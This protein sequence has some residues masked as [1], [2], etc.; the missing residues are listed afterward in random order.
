MAEIE[1]RVEIKAPREVVF[2][3]LVDLCSELRW[4]PGVE[5]MEKLTEGPVRLGTRYRAKWTQSG[6]IICECTRFDR[7][8]GWSYHNGGPIEV[9]LNIALTSTPIG[10]ILTSRFDARP[11]GLFKLIFPIFLLM[12]RKQERE[13]MV[14][15]KRYVE[16]GQHPQ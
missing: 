4:N 7:P 3:H 1:N 11:H 8:Q 12:L 10:T 5:S 9:D 13:N 14:N 15:A 6:S 2:D 16:A